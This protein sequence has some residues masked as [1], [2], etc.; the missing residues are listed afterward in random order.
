[1]GTTM[2][3]KTNFSKFNQ[4]NGVLYIFIGLTM[5][6]IPNISYETGIT[7]Y[8]FT[9]IEE[10]MV[11]LM[12]LLVMVIGYLYI[13]ATSNDNILFGKATVL[14]RLMVPLIGYMLISK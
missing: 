4:F 14:H 6:F 7:N 9:M 2:Y 10:G 8:K 11:A 3:P 1:M 12:G 5:T 13:F